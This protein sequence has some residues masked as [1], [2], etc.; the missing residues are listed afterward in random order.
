MGALEPG[1]YLAGFVMNEFPY[2]TE[3]FVIEDPGPP[4]DARV[5]L[6]VD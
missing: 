1:G 4:I 3:D 5:E 6:R 2:A